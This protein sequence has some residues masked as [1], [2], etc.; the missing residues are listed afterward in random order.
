MKTYKVTVDNYGATTWYNEEGQTHREGDL[1]AFESNAGDKYWYI[2]DQLHREGG[3]P[4]IEYANG[5]K[6]WYINGRLHREGG[7]P[8]VEFANGDKLWYINGQRVTEAEAIEYFK[9]K[10]KEVE[11]KTFLIDRDFLGTH[12]Q[13]IMRFKS[14]ENAKELYPD[15]TIKEIK[16]NF[17]IL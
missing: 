11:W 8:A 4:A 7:L 1:P 10:V 9:P 3:L 2:K 14:I 13:E 17:E 6:F 12:L 15:S 5:N 16:L